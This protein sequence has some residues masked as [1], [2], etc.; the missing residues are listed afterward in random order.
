MP[1]PTRRG[2][3]HP[4]L[5]IL[6]TVVAAVW[7][8]SA[9]VAPNLSPKNFGVVDEGRVYRSGQLTPS[10]MR[11]VHDRYHIRTVIDLG[12][13][14]AGPVL[15]DPRGNARNQRTAA[16]LHVTRYLMPLYG[17]GQGNLNWYV[18]AL[19]IMSDPAAQPV[20]VHCGA[21]SERTGIAVA[22]YEHMAHQAPLDDALKET[23]K[24]RHD[25]RRNPHV[26]EIVHQ[27]GEAIIAAARGDGRIENSPYPALPPPKPV[28]AATP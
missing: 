19:R 24:F 4:V 18:Q 16:A 13:Y 15:Q 27:W 2:G 6:V 23:S 28:V 25:P 14:W 11:A 26:E 9:A 21:G 5:L 1:F 3:I 10:A 12:S 8:Y 7:L 22:L 17:D 20:L